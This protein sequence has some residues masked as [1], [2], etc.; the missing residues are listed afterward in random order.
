MNTYAIPKSE[1]SGELVPYIEVQIGDELTLQRGVSNA[2]HD[3]VDNFFGVPF[4]VVGIPDDG[5]L[6][7]QAQRDWY[8]ESGTLI[9]AGRQS[10]VFDAEDFIFVRV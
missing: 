7:I 9:P 4:T 1:R 6:E 8:T 2:D 5:R 10:T 3:I